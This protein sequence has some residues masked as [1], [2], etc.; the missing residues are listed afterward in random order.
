[1][2]LIFITCFKL[3][4][5][6]LITH[7]FK[8]L[9]NL[10]NNN[11]LT[12]PYPLLISCRKICWCQKHLKGLV[13]RNFK[14]HFILMFAFCRDSASLSQK[15]LMIGNPSYEIKIKIVAWQSIDY[16]QVF[17]TTHGAVA[18]IR[19]KCVG[20]SMQKP[21]P[22]PGHEFELEKQGRNRLYQGRVT[23]QRQ[24]LPFYFF[25]D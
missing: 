3:V 16:A 13:F 25:Y 8:K 20:V 1:M 22:E 17:L 24:D 10:L 4:L 18:D 6:V 7:H 5:L 19:G 11:S 14:N 15:W 23:S 9:I 21:L 2:I 12:V